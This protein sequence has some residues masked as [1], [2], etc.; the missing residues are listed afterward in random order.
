MSKPQSNL[1]HVAGQLMAAPASGDSFRLWLD[2]GVRAILLD[3]RSPTT[4]FDPG[5]LVIG[6]QSLDWRQ[7]LRRLLA[8]LDERHRML[9]CDGL[10]R[11]LDFLKPEPGADDP[12][13]QGGRNGE[14]LA[15]LYLSLARDWK[16]SETLA[17]LDALIHT[18]FPAS[19]AVY[20]SALLTWRLMAD[21]DSV[22]DWR[23]VFLPANDAAREPRFRPAYAETVASGMCLAQP[24]HRAVYVGWPP[25]AQY[26]D[27][28][29][30][31]LVGPNILE[32]IRVAGFCQAQLEAA[33]T[34][35]RTRELTAYDAINHL[36]NG[37]HSGIVAS[38]QHARDQ[39]P[40]RRL[41]LPRTP[42]ES[43]ER[44][45]ARPTPEPEDRRGA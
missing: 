4:A 6:Y 26:K 38:L 7:D 29:M 18:K 11:C 21:Q 36:V 8:L 28:L 32:F 2:A 31:E 22:T 3:G 33:S 1:A 12:S 37:D 27:G 15:L 34:D 42:G 25:L 45:L 39:A 30:R 14:R 16:A 20:A 43:A 41:A 40:M 17:S 9:A 19:Q 5:L 10:R 24:R 44:S 23:Q 35:G 13:R